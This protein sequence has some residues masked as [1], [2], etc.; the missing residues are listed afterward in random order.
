MIISDLF[1]QLNTPHQFVVKFYYWLL[2]LQCVISLTLFIL[3]HVSKTHWK[4][5]K[6]YEFPV[7][8]IIF[9][10]ITL[11]MYTTNMNSPTL[12]I[13]PRIYQYIPKSKNAMPND[14]FTVHITPGAESHTA[15]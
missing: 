11:P 1:Q 2:F 8:V 4:F 15:S 10:V 9:A 5:I 7:K 14:P 12:I 13:S 6:G 3:T